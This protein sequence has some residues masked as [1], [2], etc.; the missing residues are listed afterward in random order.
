MTPPTPPRTPVT[1]P[2]AD[3][4]PGPEVVRRCLVCIR[5][6]LAPLSTADRN[7]V[8]LAL[9]WLIEDQLETLTLDTDE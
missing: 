8:L 5:D 6:E 3:C 7:R 2:T 1:H 4:S 9:Y